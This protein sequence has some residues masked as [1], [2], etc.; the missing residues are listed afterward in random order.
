MLERC[1]R[2]SRASWCYLICLIKLKN[3]KRTYLSSLLY[4]VFINTCQFAWISHHTV[5]IVHELLLTRVCN[6]PTSWICTCFIIK[7]QTGLTKL[8]C[9]GVRYADASSS[10]ITWSSRTKT[11]FVQLHYKNKCFRKWFTYNLSPIYFK[12]I[13]P[14]EIL[15][16]WA[17]QRENGRR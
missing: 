8:T 1:S 11:C 15:F 7:W 9:S 12:L 16:E 14:L 6:L 13:S 4:D 3:R 10:K 5:T 17:S 2:G